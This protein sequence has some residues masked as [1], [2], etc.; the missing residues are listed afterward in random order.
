MRYIIS[1]LGSGSTPGSLPSWA[2]PENLQRE[3]PGRLPVWRE[4]FSEHPPDIRS[5]RPSLSRAILQRKLVQPLA[6]VT[7][8]LHT[9]H[10]RGHAGQADPHHRRINA[11]VKLVL[12]HKQPNPASALCKSP[13]SPLIFDVWW[14]IRNGC[15]D[16]NIRDTNRVCALLTLK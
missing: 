13:E 7:S 16:L 3:A 10:R 9:H 15:C 6:F 4:S 11:Y 2:C 8:T 1:P 12:N 5:P 14:K